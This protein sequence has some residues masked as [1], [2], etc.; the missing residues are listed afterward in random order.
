MT[1]LFNNECREILESQ[2]K[3]AETSILVLSAFV[4]LKALRWFEQ[5]IKEGV[6]VT[7]VSRW[8][9]QDLTSGASDLE[10]YEYARDNGWK[11]IINNNMHYKIYLID[12]KK[13]FL[14][15][16]N[17]TQKGLHIA[18]DGNDEASVQI[19]PTNIDLLKLNKYVQDCCQ[20]DDNLYSKMKGYIESIKVENRDILSRQ[21]PVQICQVLSPPIT[22]LWVNDLL[23]NPPSML[24]NQS[25]EFQKHDLLLLGINDSVLLQNQEVLQVG[26]CSTT[27]WKWLLKVVKESENDYVRFGEI[28]ARLHDALLDDPKPYRKEVK[29]FL[30]NLY[31]WLRYLDLPE[32]G[33]KKFNQTEALFLK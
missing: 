1:I 17:L 24:S 32:I 31:E 20:I 13:L 11:F 7:I 3:T 26:F 5:N 28:T 23:F 16:A 12:N 15:S 29:F 4:K 30:S 19:T 10:S 9:L 25:V 18:V 2:V 8:Q 21:W 33:I 14:G 22:K 27:V 6:S